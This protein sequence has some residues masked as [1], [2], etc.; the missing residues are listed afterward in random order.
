MKMLTLLFLVFL[1]TPIE[2]KNAVETDSKPLEKKVQLSIEERIV[3]VLLDSG[4]TDINVQKV[5]IAQAKFESGNFKN[6]LSVEHNNVFSLYH[7][8]Y[9]TLSL[10]KIATAEKCKCFASYRSVEDATRAYLR[11]IAVMKIPRQGDPT[12]FAVHLKQKGY[13]VSSAKHYE[14]GLKY[15]INSLDSI[16]SPTKPNVYGSGQKT[17]GSQ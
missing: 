13:Y 14:R 4:I 16:F 12:K 8:S 17:T 10:G 15:W 3:S 11:L 7:S 5:M 2:P 1:F 9:D 6:R